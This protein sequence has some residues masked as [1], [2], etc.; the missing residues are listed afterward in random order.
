MALVSVVWPSS[1]TLVVTAAA[2]AQKAVVGMNGI[3]VPSALRRCIQRRVLHE[4]CL[5]RR[6]MS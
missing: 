3:C 5:M 2:N 4:L 6:R 1:L